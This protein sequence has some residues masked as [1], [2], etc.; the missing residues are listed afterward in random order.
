[1][2]N[3]ALLA[4]GVVCGV[5]AGLWAADAIVASW[6]E[7]FGNFELQI[8]LDLRVIL[9]LVAAMV[10]VFAIFTAAS[11]W[12]AGRLANPNTL[13][14]DGRGV[15]GQNTRAQQALLVAQIALTLTLVSGAA[16]FGVSIR[17]MYAIHFGIR[18]QNVW[19][20]LLT[21]RPGGYRNFE[22]GPYYRDMIARIESLP[23]VVSASISRDVPFFYGAYKDPVQAIDTA[24][25]SSEM[26]A[27][28]RP[29]TDHY[30]ETMGANVDTG[31]D[32]R[33]TDDT[34]HEMRVII[35]RSL[36]ERLGHGRELI[37]HHLRIGAD[38]KYQHA[39][40]VGICSD[41]DMNLANP[42]DRRPFTVF[43]DLW[44]DRDEQRYPVLMIRTAGNRLDPAAIRRIVNQGGREFVERFTTVAADIDGA[45][46]ENRFLAYLA[47]I[48]SA[49]ALVIAAVGLFG[50]ISYQVSSRTSEI[51]VRMA[52]GARPMQVQWIFLRQL[53]FILGAG[54]VL[55]VVATFGVRGLIANLLFGV[56]AF[57]PAVMAISVVLLGI[58][59]MVA[60]WA[61]LRRALKVEPGEA[62]RCE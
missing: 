11:V 39:R 32:F 26:Q 19:S 48:F 35:S 18:P 42:S 29:V 13:K 25:R 10:V 8:G 47:G 36:A 49:I 55:G 37:G 51:G 5:I 57:N 15:I 62:L 12:Q 7:M 58:V 9:F 31:E 56:G 46:I 1:M 24:Q 54:T 16:L 38:S 23:G 45:L 59:A 20:V 50:L 61:P 43:T 44:Q 22:P 41:M 30:F 21:Q 3:A 34:R 14:R 28:V 33:R 60:A 6:G 40:I 2:E 4:G 53:V 27:D 52:L 17:N